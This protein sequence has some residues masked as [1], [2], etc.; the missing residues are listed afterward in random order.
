M[1]QY[2]TTLQSNPLPFQSW[3]P[4][5]S[6]EEPVSPQGK[7]EILHFSPH[8]IP[9]C[10]GVVTDSSRVLQSYRSRCSA[11]LKTHLPE[12]ELASTRCFI[13]SNARWKRAQPLLVLLH[14]HFVVCEPRSEAQV[15]LVLLPTGLDEEVRTAPGGCR[16]A[17]GAGEPSLCS[18]CAAR[19][20]PQGLLPR[21]TA[22]LRGCDEPS[23][24]LTERG[25]HR[26]ASVTVQSEGPTGQLQNHG[27]N[28]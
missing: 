13:S 22:P 10:P 3:K 21:W 1:E 8:L 19:A 4:V 26:C 20:P 7:M 9:A 27:V 11:M 2:K 6:N 17:G 16:G 28:H 15:Q 23:R 18:P 12:A 25:A 5:L 14:H 24:P